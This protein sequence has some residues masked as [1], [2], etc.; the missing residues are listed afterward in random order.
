MEESNVLENTLA[1]SLQTLEEKKN[2]SKD[3]NQIIHN[4]SKLTG[5]DAKV[6]RRVKDY[7]YYRGLGW[8]GSSLVLDKEEKFKDRVS[9][10]FIKIKTIIEDCVATH[11]EE[12]LKCYIDDLSEFGIKI[13]FSDCKPDNIISEE[14]AKIVDETVNEGCDYQKEICQRADMIKDKH[15]PLAES[16]GFGPESE[17]TKLIDLLYKKRAL[18]KDI[19][20]KVNEGYAK[21]KLAE[22]SYIYVIND[23]DVEDN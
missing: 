14:D 15:A 23:G 3:M 16:N 10:A 17:Y 4:A 18:D 8:M 7:H 11:Q 19:A 12:L 6:I 22:K 2:Y 21:H 1:E 13:D 20:E 5:L 9:P